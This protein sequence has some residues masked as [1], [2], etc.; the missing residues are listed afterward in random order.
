MEERIEL[1][2]LDDLIVLDD[3]EVVETPADDDLEELDELA[4]LEVDVDS[5]AVVVRGKRSD[6][7]GVLDGTS[8]TSVLL[9]ETS[10][11]VEELKIEVRNP[12][13]LK[14]GTNEELIVSET[15]SELVKNAVKLG[16]EL[17]RSNE[18]VLGGKFELLGTESELLNG[19]MMASELL[20][21]GKVASSLEEA[22]VAAKVSGAELVDESEL[23]TMLTVVE[24][25][26]SELV[27]ILTVVEV[28]SS[29]E[30]AEDSA[31]VSELELGTDSELATILETGSVVEI[32]SP[33]ISVEL[34]ILIDSLKLTKTSELVE[35]T[36]LGSPAE[37]SA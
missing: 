22:G 31:E 3:L 14:S 23:V 10:T 24:V 37:L 15:C 11:I 6:S 7:V 29:L 16:D 35:T 4:G 1:E 12:V 5:G 32:S 8:I 26:S 28:T 33:G 2:E 27:T 19:L 17:G 25:A 30:K 18:G 34:G 20:V 21:V 36:A 13:V 9:E